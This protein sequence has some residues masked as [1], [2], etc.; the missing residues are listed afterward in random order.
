MEY[1]TDRFGCSPISHHSLAQLLV[2][3]HPKIFSVPPLKLSMFLLLK[4]LYQIPIKKILLYQITFSSF[5]P[6]PKQN[7]ATKLTPTHGRQLQPPHPHAIPDLPT[8]T[9]SIAPPP[10]PLQGTAIKRFFSCQNQNH[11]RRVSDL[12]FMGERG[13]VK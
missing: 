10:S 13:D 5:A 9:S 1:C 3:H 4:L 2:Q 11:R 12:G 6:H 8:P 7:P